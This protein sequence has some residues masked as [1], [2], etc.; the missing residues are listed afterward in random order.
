MDLATRVSPVR[1]MPPSQ[2]ILDGL[3][4][5]ANQ[6]RPIAIA[7]HLSLGVCLIALL[8]GWR[9]QRRLAGILL[10]VPL[11]SVSVL[12]W[13]GGN[14]FNGT[15]FAA[16]M[17]ALIGVA[18]SWPRDPVRVGG[19]WLWIPGCL[20]LAFGWTYPHFLQAD[21]WAIYLYAAPMGLIPCPTLS[22]V[23]GACLLLDGLGSRWWSPMVAAPGLLYG[24]IGAFRLGVR[25]DVVLVVGAVILAVVPVAYLRREAA[26]LSGDR[27]SP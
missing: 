27:L 21:S 25:I 16:V 19:P 18:L 2:E 26:A 12:A 17:I 15:V 3:A 24:V 20:L 8:L 23:G 7:W 5:I 14:P 4:R 13:A 22:V 6:W 10:A 9:P 1:R 11:G